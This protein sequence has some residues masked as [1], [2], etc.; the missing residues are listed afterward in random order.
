METRVTVENAH[1]Q[2]LTATRSASGIEITWTDKKTTAWARGAQ[3]AFV[4]VD[5]PEGHYGQVAFRSSYG[6]YLSVVEIP[7]ELQLRDTK[8]R[9]DVSLTCSSTHVTANER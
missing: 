3:Q 4:L 8:L 9:A 6:T 1:G 7:Q 5:S 2:F